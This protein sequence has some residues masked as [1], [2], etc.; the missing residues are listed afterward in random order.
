MKN[1]QYCTTP[2]ATQVKYC[3]LWLGTS[4]TTEHLVRAYQCEDITGRLAH[5][6]RQL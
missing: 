4:Q 1:K 2:I 5:Y 3:S 6:R